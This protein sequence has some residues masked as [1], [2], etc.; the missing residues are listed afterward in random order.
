MDGVKH[1]SCKIRRFKMATYAKQ[2]QKI[3]TA[4][5]EANQPWPASTREIA[6][7]AVQRKLWQPQSSAIIDQ[8]ANQLG[9]AL[10]EEH[11][12]DA[13]GRTVRA[14][15]VAKIERDG[16]QIPL[17]GDI[18][19]ASHQHLKLA[20]QQRRQQIVGDCRQLKTDMD[21]YNEN[22]NPVQPIQISF[23]F[24]YDLEELAAVAN[25]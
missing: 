19:S 15:H 6:T 12:I 21:S 3:V 11:I 7:W 16:V 17:W 24:T 9:R 4:Y 22:R 14:K 10:R 1:Q 13:Q 20:F 5:V 23:N 18:R 25:F 2:L 8:C